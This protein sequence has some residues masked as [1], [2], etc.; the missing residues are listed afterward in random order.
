MVLAYSGIGTTIRVSSLNCLSAVSLQ[1]CIMH[2]I[3]KYCD[4]MNGQI[5]TKRA[6]VFFQ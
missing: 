5:D 3:V 2:P 1:H 4:V 6:N